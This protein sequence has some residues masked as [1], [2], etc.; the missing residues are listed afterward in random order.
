MENESGLKNRIWLIDILKRSQGLGEEL[1][2]RLDSFVSNQKDISV[3]ELGMDSLALMQLSVDI[4]DEL[5]FQV[6][7]E[8]LTKA[9]TLGQILE[10]LN[11]NITESS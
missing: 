8:D 4:E 10:V 9:E 7:L 1:G 5:G 6:S 2:S 11:R 3:D